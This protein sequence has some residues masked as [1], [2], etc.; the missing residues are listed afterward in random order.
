M[1]PSLLTAIVLAQQAASAPDADLAAILEAERAKRHVPAAA[2]WVSRRGEPVAVAAVG[3]RRANA[4]DPVT[5]DDRFH[6]ASVSKSLNATL[7]ATL[8]DEGKLRWDETVEEMFPDWPVHRALRAVTLAQLLSHRSGLAGF[9][10]SGDF[11]EAPTLYGDTFSRRRQFVQWLVAQKPAGE[12]GTFS[13]SNAGVTV[14]AAA[15]EAAAGK[16]WETLMRDRVFT[17]LRMTHA[18]FGWPGRVDINEPWGH[19]LRGARYAPHDPRGSYEVVDV[20]APATDVHLS[21]RDLGAFL[22][23]QARGLNGLRGLLAPQTYRRMHG[24]TGEPALG[25][26]ASRTKEGRRLSRHDG[27]AEIFYAVALVAFDE[28]LEIGILLNAADAATA[29]GILAATWNRF[30]AAVPPKAGG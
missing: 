26:M 4:G 13:Y 14:A 27:N 7:I 30:R 8:V 6:S 16:P 1:L 17:P 10:G 9:R 3:L 24:F 2:A 21:I 15:A 23:D 28:E 5:V 25:W 18:G 19:E 11:A 22:A 29:N 20:L 12:A